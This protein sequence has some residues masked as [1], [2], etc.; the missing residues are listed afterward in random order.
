MFK[1]SHTTLIALSGLTWLIVGCVL[2]P[3]GLNF[4]VGAILK[5][6]LLTMSRP[7]LDN[8]APLVGG[9][10][11][12]ALIL[13]VAGLCVGYFK[14]R[15][16]FTKTVEASVSRIL[17]LPNPTSL[18]QMYTKKY[19]ILL[20]SMV[21]LGFIVRLAPTDVRGFIDVIVGAALINGAVYYFRQAIHVYKNGNRA[22]V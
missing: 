14:G 1:A 3:L 7:I 22:A 10:D 21:L 12:A 2:L 4:I 13:V 15:F 19:Y 17:S 16:I 6:N 20:G 8:L 18:L 5:E 9:L 11:Q